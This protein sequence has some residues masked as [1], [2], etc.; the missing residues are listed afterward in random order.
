L[1]AAGVAVAAILYRWIGRRAFVPLGDRSLALLLERRFDKFHD[2]LVTAVEMADLPGHAS[3]FSRELLARTTDEARA[4]ADSVSYLHVFNI[5]ALLQKLAL[6]ILVGGSLF[7]LYA[8]N[9][10]ALER[11]A[12][13][14]Y[15]LSDVPWP[16]SAKIEVVGIEIIRRLAPNDDSPR[17]VTIPFDHNVVKVARGTNV[18]LKVR[19]AAPPEADI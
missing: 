9:A 10:N 4:G 19:A 5:T 15:L 17:T 16:R 13:R 18:S 7:G 14:L 11:A 12:Q 1:A 6:A 3:V 2:S 8:V